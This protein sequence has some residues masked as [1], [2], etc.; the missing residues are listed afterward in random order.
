MLS[1]L[2]NLSDSMPF[3]FLTLAGAG[4]LFFFTLASLSYLLLF[5]WCRAKFHPEYQPNWREIRTA[6]KWAAISVAGNAALTTP[7][8]WAIANGHGRVYYDVAAHGWGWLIASI[9]LLIVVTETLIYWIHRGLHTPLGWTLH[10]THHQF[11]VTTPWVGVAFN[12][13]DSFAQ[14]LPH[15]LCAF[16]FPMH[17][18]VYLLSYPPT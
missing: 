5:V 3:L 1:R 17:A 10:R 16:L 11:K 15:H 4:L 8:H 14:A 2:F 12:P 6:M 18:V 7:I 13:L 9:T